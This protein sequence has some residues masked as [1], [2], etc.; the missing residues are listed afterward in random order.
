M[1]FCLTCIKG[2]GEKGRK[3]VTISLFQTKFLQPAKQFPGKI[4]I[5]IYKH[6]FTTKNTDP[7][8]DSKFNNWRTTTEEAAARQVASCA[9]KVQLLQPGK[10]QKQHTLGNL[11][12]LWSWGKH[13]GVESRNKPFVRLGYSDSVT[14][15]WNLKVSSGLQ[16]LT[17][18]KLL[19]SKNTDLQNHTTNPLCHEWHLFIFSD[20]YLN[21]F[22]FLLSLVRR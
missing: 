22:S 2:D 6:M 5:Q 18:L 12:W 17:A 10:V 13:E 7:L 15:F 11:Q 8:L 3:D 20:K 21:Y 19:F 16:D 4:Y 14:A 9:G 1:Y